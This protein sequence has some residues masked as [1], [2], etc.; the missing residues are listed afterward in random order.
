MPKYNYTPAIPL[1]CEYEPDSG[2]SIKHTLKVTDDDGIERSTETRVPI[3]GSEAKREALLHFITKFTRA[4]QLM[5]WND[6]PTLLS[7][8]EMHLQGSYQ[9]D[10]QEIID[11]TDPADD[12]TVEFFE[13]QVQNMLTDISQ[14]MNGLIWPITFAIVKSQIP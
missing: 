10:W 11:S 13:E 3:V 4:R 1:V 6:G 9:T 7:K 2:E 14:K 5:S 8:I 12:R